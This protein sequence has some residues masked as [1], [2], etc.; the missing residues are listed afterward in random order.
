MTALE[1]KRHLAEWRE[2]GALVDLLPEVVALDGVHQPPEYHAEGD[3]LTH[4]FM[5]VDAV[6]DDADARVFWAVLLH[7]IGKVETTEYVD[8]RWRSHGHAQLGASL[9]PGILERFGLDHIADSVA[10]LVKHHHFAF[11]WG[12]QVIKGLSKKQIKFCKNPLFPL[13]VEV[14]RAD[15]AASLGKS[16]KGDFLNSI[17]LLWEKASKDNL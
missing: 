16:Q 17:L 2:T 5:A 14:C 8:G 3:A 1:W 12:K 13:L 6:S 4:T 10:W 7:D 15:A 9:V 11:S